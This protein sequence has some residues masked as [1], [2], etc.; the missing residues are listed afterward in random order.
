MRHFTYAAGPMLHAEAAAFVDG[1][2]FAGMKGNIR[3]VMVG[4]IAH[5]GTVSRKLANACRG[6]G[7]FVVVETE[8]DESETVEERVRSSGRLYTL[9]VRK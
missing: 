5:A 1:A 8:E 4:D 6:S 9:K 2:K 7:L 3:V